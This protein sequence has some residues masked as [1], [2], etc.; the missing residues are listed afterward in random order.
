MF[1]PSFWRIKRFA[2][3]IPEIMDLQREIN[4]LFSSAA[5]TSADFPAVNVWGKDN[6]LVVTTELPGVDP[7]KSIFPSMG[8]Y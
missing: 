2:D 6:Q 8:Q 4:R 3:N 5:Q 7:E 1:N